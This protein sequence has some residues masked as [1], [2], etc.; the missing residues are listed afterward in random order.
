MQTKIVDTRHSHL[1]AV[2]LCHAAA[3]PESLATALGQRY[4]SRMLSWYLSSNKTF[5]FHLE[6]AA[7]GKCLG[8]CG[9]MV[10]DG[11]LGM[12]SASSMAQYAFSAAVVGFLT[13]PWVLFHPEVRAK[14]PLLRKNILMKLG[15]KKKKHIPDSQKEEMA[16]Q[17]K[18]GLVVIGV[19]PAYHGQGFGSILLKEFERRATEIY[20][21]RKLYLSVRADNEKAIRAYEKNGW[22][23]GDLRGN[24]LSMIKAL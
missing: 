19:D 13:H 16:K 18:L 14:W 21:I 6:D 17:P 10:S 3:F 7:E 24:S 15:L 5:L 22:V 20:G 12:G 9:G 1:S 23:Q 8:Y 11:S 4:V 2:A